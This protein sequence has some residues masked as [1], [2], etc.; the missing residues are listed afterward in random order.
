MVLRNKYSTRLNDLN[1]IDSFFPLVNDNNFTDLLLYLNDEFDDKKN[2][3][4]L[5]S[6]IKLI[7]KIS[8]IL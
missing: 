6:T 5:K 4:I 7:K 2:F 1:D 3:W 8:N